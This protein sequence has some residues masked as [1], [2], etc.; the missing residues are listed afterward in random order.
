MTQ[1][2]SNTTVPDGVRYAR[3]AGR[4]LGLLLI[5]MGIVSLIGDS[6]GSSF[7]RFKAIYFVTYGGLLNLPFKRI[8]WK[9]WKWSYGVLVASSVAFVFVMV[10]SVIFDYMAADA[11]GERLGVPGFEGT[12][13]FFALLQVP[14][15]LFQRRPDLLD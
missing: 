4:L 11:R 9:Q 13:I 15:V 10:V 14:V 5:C 3:L 12:L 8:A 1:E 6:H 2:L 7:A